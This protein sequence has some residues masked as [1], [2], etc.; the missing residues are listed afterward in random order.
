MAI[1]VGGVLLEPSVPHADEKGAVAKSAPRSWRFILVPMTPAIMPNAGGRK[2]PPTNRSMIERRIRTNP[3]FFLCTSKA[4]HARTI[5][6]KMM[7]STPV[8]KKFGMT[9]IAGRHA[10]P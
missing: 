4:A 7:A 5:R 9:V 1:G 2:P 10:L 8:T 6:A 3:P